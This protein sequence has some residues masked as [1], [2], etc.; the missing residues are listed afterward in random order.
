MENPERQWIGLNLGC[1]NTNLA[2][3]MQCLYAERSG[4]RFSTEALFPDFVVD[5]ISSSDADPVVGE[6]LWLRDSNVGG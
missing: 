3:A 6:V 5:W 4:V 1:E 2:S